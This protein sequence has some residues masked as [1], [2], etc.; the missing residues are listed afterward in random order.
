[1]RVYLHCS[2]CLALNADDLSVVTLYPESLEDN[3]IYWIRCK[4]GHDSRIYVGEMK[5]QVLFQIGLHA[6]VDS[7]TREAVV[8]FTAALERFYEFYLRVI[9]NKKDIPAD[10]LTKS[11]KAVE[12]QSERQ[13]GAYLFTYLIEHGELAPRLNDTS[14]KL[15]NQVVHKGHIPSE[16]AAIEYGQEIADLIIPVLNRLKADYNDALR[17]EIYNYLNE[18]TNEKWANKPDRVHVSAVS[19]ETLIKM[20]Q[21]P[22]DQ[23][24]LREALSDINQRRSSFSTQR[25]T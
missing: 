9:S 13:L 12:S 19:V 4:E 6:I 1:M 18:R 8:S 11:W 20:D 10:A 25:Y 14:V 15:R 17:R 5:F 21:K 22:Q 7:Y 24:S 16:K 23:L 2:K 3:G